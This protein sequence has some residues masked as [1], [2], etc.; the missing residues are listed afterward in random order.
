[1]EHTLIIWSTTT[2]TMYTAAIATTTG[3]L[4]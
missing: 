2:S 1:M 4:Q 3:A